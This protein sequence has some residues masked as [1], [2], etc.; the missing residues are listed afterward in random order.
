MLKRLT[1]PE[2]Q[3]TFKKYTA[4]LGAVTLVLLLVSTKVSAVDYGGIGGK[5]AYPRTENP[6]T[7]SIFVHTTEVG[8]TINEGVKVVNNSAKKKTI[9]VYAVDSE[10]SS[11]GAF[12]CKQLAE[13]KKDVGSWINLEKTEITL[14]SL[15]SEVVPFKISVPQNA[16]IGE[17]N[18]CI[19]IQEKKES[20]NEPGVN[21]T[22]RSGIRVALLIPGDITRKLEIA[23][24]EILQRDN[25]LRILRPKVKNLGNVSIDANVHVRTDYFFGKNYFDAG[26]Q[27]PILRG[28]TSDWNFEL[29]KP[30]WGGFYKSY[31]TVEYDE[32]KEAGVGTSSGKGLTKLNSATTTFFVFPALPA[33]LIELLILA[34]FISLLYLLIRFIKNK[35]NVKKNWVEYIV[36]QGE[37]V[38]TIAE[39]HAVSWKTLAGA[40][41]LKPPYNLSEGQ[42]IKVPPKK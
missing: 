21:L 27:Y 20:S 28:E 17:H 24:F 1:R 5:P 32:N 7:E 36:G 34:L 11:G 2:L 12:A 33:L 9:L 31:F 3:C 25:N 13:D 29:Q 22:F 41:K 42:V 15:K 40:N 16:S 37:N 26:G 23:G 39:R 4:L 6:R 30:Y 14:D 38:N 19:I 18:G 8:K 35:K 10:V